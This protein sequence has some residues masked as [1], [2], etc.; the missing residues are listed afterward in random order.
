MKG[1]DCLDNSF[2]F[3]RTEFKFIASDDILHQVVLQ[4][5]HNLNWDTESQHWVQAFSLA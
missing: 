5:Y 4:G 2:T 3:A 1:W